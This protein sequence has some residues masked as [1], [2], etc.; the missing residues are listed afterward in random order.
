MN[1]ETDEEA[2]G[3]LA[4]EFLSAH[5]AHRTRVR[6]DSHQHFK[7]ILRAHQLSLTAIVS[8]QDQAGGLKFNSGNG[9]VDGRMGLIAQFIQGIALAFSATSEG[10]YP[11]AA[12]LMKQELETILAIAEYEEGK[13]KEKKTPQFKGKMTGWAKH[14]GRLNELAHPSRSEIV[15]NFA[16]YSDGMGRLAGPTTIPQYNAEAYRRLLGTQALMMTVLF[17]QMKKLYQEVFY[18]MPDDADDGLIRSAV[19]ILTEEKIAVSR[20]KV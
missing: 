5:H 4:N 6:N 7:S 1:N 18:I 3:G 15:Q 12:N 8:F 14:Y 19:Q 11:Q 9:N 16:Y 20:M 13:R 2:I 17:V 10:L